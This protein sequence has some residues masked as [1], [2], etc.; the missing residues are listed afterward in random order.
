MSRKSPK[1]YWLPGDPAKDRPDYMSESLYRA[2]L[3][4]EEKCA[5]PV[6]VK[7]DDIWRAYGRSSECKF[8]VWLAERS[9]P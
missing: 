2:A 1:T 8:E 5:V 9:R 3:E 4:Q 7:W 6:S